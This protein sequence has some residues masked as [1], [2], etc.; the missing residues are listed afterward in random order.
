VAAGTAESTLA[1]VVRRL[2]HAPP[3]RVFAAWTMPEHLRRWWGPRPVTCSGAE[4]DLRVGG[5][6]RIDNL[7]PDGSV[8]VIRG[9]FIA[10]VPPER[11][12]YTW[13][14]EPGPSAAERVT[15]RFEARG[16]GTEV[17]V[18][19]EKILDETTK[20]SHERGWE[21]CLD[22]LLAYLGT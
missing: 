10:V 16:E 1:L 14:V 4:V 13:L 8:V 21:G 15:V 22:G 7:L 6:Y 20:G 3:E 12:E 19:H 11:L 17:I 2:I 5:R 9:E 18:V